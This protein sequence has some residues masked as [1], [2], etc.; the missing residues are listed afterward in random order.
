MYPLNSAGLMACLVA[1]LPFF[2][3]TLLSTLLFGG[4]AAYVMERTTAREPAAA[5]A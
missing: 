5:V 1:G 3:N 4:V 2:P